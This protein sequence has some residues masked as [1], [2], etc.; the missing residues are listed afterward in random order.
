MTHTQTNNETAILNNLRVGTKFSFGHG[1]ENIFEVT[2]G[3]FDHGIDESFITYKLEAHAPGCE[4]EY[5]EVGDEWHM[6]ES[7]ANLCEVEIVK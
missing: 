7:E 3:G 6:E 5:G 4:D 1:S 2:G